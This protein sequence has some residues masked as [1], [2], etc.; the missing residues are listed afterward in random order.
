MEGSTITNEKGS[1]W[2]KDNKMQGPEIA[3]I[4]RGAGGDLLAGEAVRGCPVDAP[5]LDHCV[6]TAGRQLAAI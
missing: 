6:I 5:H 3:V 2:G 4:E 1:Q